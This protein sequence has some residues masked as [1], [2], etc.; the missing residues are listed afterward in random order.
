MAQIE[1]QEDVSHGAATKMIGM[2][3]ILKLLGIVQ[4]L[5]VVSLAA[6]PV[7]ADLRV[8][9]AKSLVIDKE[10]YLEVELREIPS[11]K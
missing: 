9:A 10:H 11:F 7:N 2:E 4:Q 1:T 5:G 3:L 6:S 8:G